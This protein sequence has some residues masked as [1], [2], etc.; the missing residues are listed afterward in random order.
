MGSN[1]ENQKQFPKEVCI[2]IV[3]ER[4]RIRNETG[5]E[6]KVKVKTT[7]FCLILC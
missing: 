6:T 5:K 3:R 7:M 4:G 2:Y 1:G